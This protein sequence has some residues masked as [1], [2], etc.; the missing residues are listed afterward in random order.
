MVEKSG[1]DSGVSSSSERAP[2]VVGSGPLVQGVGADAIDDILQVPVSSVEHALSILEQGPPRTDELPVTLGMHSSSSAKRG[3]CF[4][5][6]SGGV[7]SGRDK[8]SVSEP[9]IID[10]QKGELSQ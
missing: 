4:F 9:V 7:L 2:V 5:E 10:F 3:T 1:I 6:G 8:Y